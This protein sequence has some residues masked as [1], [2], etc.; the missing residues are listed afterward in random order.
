MGKE[1][2]LYFFE[3]NEFGLVSKG[4]EAFYK[5][6]LVYDSDGSK[7]LINGIKSIQKTPILTTIKYFQ[8]MYKVE[9]KCEK[10]LDNISLSDFKQIIIDHI[11]SHK[12]YW[13]SRDTFAGLRNSILAK[14]NFFEIITFL[15]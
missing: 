6:G 7:Y 3:E 11:H 15:K 5:K 9:V 8:P 2:P 14:N 13:L 1:A 10:I 4:G 12:K